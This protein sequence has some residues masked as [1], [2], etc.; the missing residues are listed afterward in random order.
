MQVEPRMLMARRPIRGISYLRRALHV[1]RVP[2]ADRPATADG[3]DISIRARRLCGALAIVLVTSTAVAGE[4]EW[5][6]RVLSATGVD[7]GLI[8]HLGCGDGQ[9]TSTLRTSD[10]CLVQGLDTDWQVVQAARQR[11]Q[12]LGDYGPVSFDLFDGRHLPYVDNLV[13]LV[14]AQDLGEVTR[15]EVLRVLAPLGVA[16][17]KQGNVWKKIEKPWPQDIDEWTHYLHGAD[18]NPVANDLV[19]G[20]PQHYQWVS[21]PGVG[22]VARNRFESAEP[23]HG[24]RTSVLHCQRSS[25]QSCR[26]RVAARQMVTD[27]S[28]CLQRP[29]SCGRCRSNIGVGGNGNRPGSRR[30]RVSFR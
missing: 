6:Q 16:Y 30:G 9:L 5:A 28:R 2:V 1:K 19:V 12:K 29:H 21:R 23:G 13:N 8:V 25:D 14:V 4:Q 3:C 10:R 22:P 26:P 17:V 20:P 7:R 27:S 18:G 24:S 11:I 15:E